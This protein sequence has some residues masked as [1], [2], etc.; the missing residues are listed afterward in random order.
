MP[1]WTDTYWK[2]IEDAAAEI[3]GRMMR[4]ECYSACVGFV[5]AP[6]QGTGRYGEFGRIVPLADHDPKPDG[7]ERGGVTVTAAMTRG[8]M[9]REIERGSRR[10][11]I[12]G[13]DTP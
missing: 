11:P 1:K 9:A 2:M 6:G 13:A 7:W 3:H 12:L 4:G 5:P 8:E 10:W